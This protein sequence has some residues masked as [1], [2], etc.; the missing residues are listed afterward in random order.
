MLVALV[1]LAIVGLL[2]WHGMTA[3][4]RGEQ[5]ISVPL[6]RSFDL[7]RA[8]AQLRIDGAELAMPW[9]IEKAALFLQ[10]QA[11][12]MVRRFPDQETAFQ[13]VRYSV[14][15]HQFWR[16]VSAPLYSSRALQ[17]ALATQLQSGNTVRQSGTAV[18]LASRVSQVQQLQVWM[19]QSGWTSDNT[20]I[21]RNYQNARY[22]S[23]FGIHRT[24]WLPT[25][26][27]I[28]L[29]LQGKLFPITWTVLLRP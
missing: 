8:F 11:I 24:D 23:S 20:V 13:I 18:S 14:A 25:G 28:V 17:A 15:K 19:R 22:M 29:T 7:S 12:I 16:S 3:I 10:P 9:N 5:H 6:Q 1:V 21:Q 26:L 27:R 2:S 4:M